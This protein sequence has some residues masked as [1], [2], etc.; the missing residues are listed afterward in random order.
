MQLA[1]GVVAALL[2]CPP[3]SAGVVPPTYGAVHDLPELPGS[4]SDPGSPHFGLDGQKVELGY[5]GRVRIWD[6]KVDEYLN[7]PAVTLNYGRVLSDRFAAGA[8]LRRQN[9]FSDFWFNGVFAPKRDLRLHVAGGQLRTSMDPSA[10]GGSPDAVMQNSYLVGAQHY[11]KDSLVSHVDIST[12]AVE[13]STDNGAAAT[14]DGSGNLA[15]GRQQGNVL[16]L[17]LQPLPGSHI[18]LSRESRQLTYV[19]RGENQ[20]QQSTV[21]NRLNFTQRLDDCLSLQ[22]GYSTDQQVD[23]L[24]LKLARNKWY[25]SVSRSRDGSNDNMSFGVGYQLP[26]GHAPGDRSKCTAPAPNA[27]TFGP[28]IDATVQ[29]PDQFPSGPLA[30][31]ANGG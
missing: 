4:G 7:S 15:P 3:S 27:P 8:A 28:L 10:E 24:N 29:R 25:I 17:S 1:A 22:G 11:W 16:N 12:Y 18:D 6:A 14:N 21:S 9:N 23:Q 31:A 19:Y 13:A 30:I 2:C 5:G 26:L 20:D